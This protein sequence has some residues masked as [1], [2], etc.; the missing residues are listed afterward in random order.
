MCKFF[1]PHSECFTKYDVF[2]S[3]IFDYACLRRK[4]IAIKEVRNY[5]KTVYI[6]KRCWKWLVGGC[7]VLI[8]FS[9]IRPW[10]ISYRNYQKSLAYFS[11]LAPLILFFLLKRRVK[12]GDGPMAQCPVNTLLICTLHYFGPKSTFLILSSGLDSGCRVRAKKIRP[13]PTLLLSGF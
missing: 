9:C 8:L 13:R 7:I 4:I 12:R 5:E 11:H 3:H 1:D 10:A 2:C 6:K